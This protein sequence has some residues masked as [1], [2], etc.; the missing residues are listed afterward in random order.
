[1]RLLVLILLLMITCTSCLPDGDARLAGP[2]SLALDSLDLGEIVAGKSRIRRR[3]LNKSAR[4]IRIAEFETSCTCTA[5]IPKSLILRPNSEQVIEFELNVNEADK[6][7]AG[8]QPFSAKVTAHFTE[9]QWQSVS[10][11]LQGYVLNPIRFD[12]NFVNFGEVLAQLS[13]QFSKDIRFF[14]QVD[15]RE[16]SV[17]GP[18]FFNLELLTRALEH[19]RDNTVRISL[20]HPLLPSKFRDSILIHTVAA[21]GKVST[22]RLAIFGTVLGEVNV[23]PERL[24]MGA[25]AVGREVREYFM[26]RSSLGRAFNVSNI[27]CDNKKDQAQVFIERVNRTDND[28]QY[29][30]CLKPLREGIISF[31]AALTVTTDDNKTLDLRFPVSAVGRR[32]LE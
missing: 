9:P 1:M 7:N 31:T 2:Q 19:G 17:S 25:V 22:T 26:V 10:W 16:I 4:S 20:R 15:L 5:V 12:A 3:I 8:H 21:T 24:S 6:V 13:G 14:N 11:V 32:S 18:E 29:R 23:S 27:S 30:V 28:E